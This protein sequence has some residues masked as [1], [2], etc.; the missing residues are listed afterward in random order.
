MFEN[1]IEELIPNKN[2]FIIIFDG[3]DGLSEIFYEEVKI[4]GYKNLYILEDGID[5]WRNEGYEL[6]MMESMFLVKLLENG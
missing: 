4:L 3:N 2:V 6:F 5:G 1:K